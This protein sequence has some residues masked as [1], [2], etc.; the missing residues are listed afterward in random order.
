M[1]I[2][3]NIFVSYLSLG[4]ACMSVHGTSLHAE[5]NWLQFRG[6]NFN[7]V[8]SDAKLPIEFGGDEK[9]NIAW[10]TEIPG[11]SVGGVIVVGDQVIT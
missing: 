10:R 8:V 6:S 3:K 5:K 7:P 11:R 9:K 4:L 2:R 1:H